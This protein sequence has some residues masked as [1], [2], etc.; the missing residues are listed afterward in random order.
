MENLEQQPTKQFKTSADLEAM[1]MEDLRKV[2]GC[3][4]QGVT[5][6][7]Y[8]IP[9]N[10]MLMFGAAAGPVRNKNE[11]KQFFEIITDR[12]KRLYDIKFDQHWHDAK[13][14]ACLCPRQGHAG[15]GQEGERGS[16][17]TQSTAPAARNISA[18]EKRASVAP[19]NSTYKADRPFFQ[20]EPNLKH[21][22][23]DDSNAGM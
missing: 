11:L 20:S 1:I 2:D 12:L 9:W 22:L 13:P 3:P 5:V 14:S 23:S 15:V 10:A 17:E 7:V 16:S 21:L 4:Q 6:T 18:D 8:G 19:P